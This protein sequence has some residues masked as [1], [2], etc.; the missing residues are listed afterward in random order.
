MIIFLFFLIVWFVIVYAGIPKLYDFGNNE[1]PKYYEDNDS[2]LP[3]YWETANLLYEEYMQ[4][5]GPAL[6]AR[7]N[8]ETWAVEQFRKATA[9]ANMEYQQKLTALWKEYHSNCS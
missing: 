4:T 5:I 2:R 8:A 9:E 6:E 7:K 1:N 3:K